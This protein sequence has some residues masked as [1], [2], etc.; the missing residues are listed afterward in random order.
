MSAHILHDPC[1]RGADNPCGFCLNTET[2][3][4]IVLHVSSK[5]TTID[6]KNSRCPHLRKLN[7]TAAS[8]FS[9]PRSPCT[10]YPL[11]CPLCEPKSPAVWK[12]NLRAHI[13]RHHATAD[14][15]LY[16]KYYNVT[17]DEKTL[18]KAIF[19]AKPRQVG[20]ANTEPALITSDIHST[21]AALR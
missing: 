6:M 14:I 2:L 15:S 21:R 10:N 1:M 9:P 17:D 16:K 19:Q 7:L 11:E 12:Y 13:I 5:A 20:P 3:C 8:K 4:S 18:M